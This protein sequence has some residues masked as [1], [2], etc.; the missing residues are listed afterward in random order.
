MRSSGP[1][2]RWSKPVSFRKVS[3]KR[4]SEMLPVA[5]GQGMDIMSKRKKKQQSLKLVYLRQK[6]GKRSKTK[7]KEGKIRPSRFS[8]P[9]FEGFTNGNG[10]LNPWSIVIPRSC[11]AVG[12]EP[13]LSLVQGF[14]T[15]S[16][17]RNARKLTAT[18]DSLIARFG[19]PLLIN[20][21]S[22]PLLWFSFKT[23]SLEHLF[24]STPERRSCVYSDVNK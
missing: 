3:E 23:R 1:F 5:V 14:D 15:R 19:T 22:G 20:D 4:S 18:L 11:P 7:T 6:K 13:I 21:I 24:N 10:Q 16:F 12:A 2:M 8:T 9:T 17:A